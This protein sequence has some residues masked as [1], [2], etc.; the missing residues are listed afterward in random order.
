[1]KTEV[2]SVATGSTPTVVDLTTSAAGFVSGEG[3]GLLNVFVPHATA[4]VAIIETG[5]G[6]DDD[7]LDAIER[8]FPRD[9]GLYR[10]RHGAPGHGSDHVVPAWI[11]PSVVV[12]VAD[13]T[14]RLG[15]WQSIVLVDPNGDNRRRDV[16]LTFM[17]DG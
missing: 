5:A 1:V 3:D 13:G 12:P 11:G 17:R 10:H 9:D 8:L 4:G 15:T 2:I 14:L 7:L 6:S 16:I